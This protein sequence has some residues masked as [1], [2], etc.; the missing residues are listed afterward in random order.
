MALSWT[1]ELVPVLQSE[2]KK[3][4][5][6]DYAISGTEAKEHGQGKGERRAAQGGKDDGNMKQPLVTQLLPHQLLGK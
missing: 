2:D 3:V 5:L 6:L 4:T 1:I